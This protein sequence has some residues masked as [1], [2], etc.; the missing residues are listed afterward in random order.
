MSEEPALPPALVE[1][2]VFLAWGPPAYTM[3]S[4]LLAA[5]LGLEVEHIFSTRRRGLLAAPVKYPYQLV[6]TVSCLLRKRPRVV[7]VQHPPSIAVMVVALY[8]LVARADYVVDA[9][10]DAFLSRYWSRPEWLQ[11]LLSR[12]ALATIVTNDHFAGIVRA[13]GGRACIIRNIAGEFDHGPYPLGPEFNVAVVAT[14]APDEPI[15]ELF[16]AAERLPD[17]RFRVTG[18][19]RRE[20]ALIPRTIPDNVELT[21]YL[22]S[23]D[24]YGLLHES[25]AVMTLTIRDHTMQRG[26]CEAVSLGTPVITSRWPLLTDY[27]CK[28]T[29][30]VDNTADG[31]AAGVVQMRANSERY[32]EEILELRDDT[33][34]EWVAARDELVSFL[35]GGGVDG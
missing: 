19:P 11:R 31:I 9:H 22:S 28:G 1:R 16:A 32:R 29:V 20:N 14:F 23:A 18:D 33:V 21:G 17:V 3:R 7:F 13:R 25:D 35:P 5:R 10:S 15:G 26:A 6:V 2:S 4:R 27:F 8:A 12:R 34:K 24:Y 30:H